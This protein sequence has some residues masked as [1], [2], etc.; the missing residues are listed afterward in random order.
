MTA[1]RVRIREAGDGVSPAGL[2]E[3]FG[4]MDGAA[5]LGGNECDTP[6][7]RFSYWMAE[8]V[9]VLEIPTSHPSPLEAIVA[10]TTKHTFRGGD[11]LPTE[12]MLC[13]GWVGY[14][15]YDL[16]RAI[17]RISE[18][19][20]DDMRM[21]L[22]RMGFYDRLICR[23]RKAGKWWLVVLEM[24]DEDVESKFAWL[25]ARLREAGDARVKM[26]PAAAEADLSKL[27]S[28]MTR[29]YY[30]EAMERIRKYIWDGEFYQINLS[31]RF[32]REFTGRAVDLF[33]WQSAH[34]ACPYA[35]YLD[36]GRF[37]VASASMEMF[38]TIRG[39]QIWTSPIKGTR[40]RMPG[41]ELRNQ[42]SVRE[43]QESVKERA[44]LNM[45]IDLER[46]DLG[47]ICEYGSIS[48][49]E[50][51]HV[52]AYPTVFHALATVDG[53]LREGV[54]FCEVLRA[55]FPG[56]SITGAPKIR[57]MEAIEELEPTR[58][59]LYTGSIGYIGVDG[60]VC[61]NI[62]IRTIII[63]GGMAWA[64]TGGGI[65][66]DSQP[67]AEWE[68]TLTK[69]MALAAGIE[70]VQSAGISLWLKKSF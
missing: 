53:T 62:A 42:Q 26:W 65:V 52:E 51:R 40:R 61:L 68:E 63:S 28:N 45:V 16:G 56:G 37:K 58:R 33:Q 2:N 47:R 10:A 34:N 35:A 39:R 55:M 57:V 14:F 54:G 32:C 24:G 7:N 60:N 43:L 67:Q 41:A 64:Q 66:A 15:S 31:Q 3:V 25:E 50:P 13:G 29:E 8:P 19:A 18:R 46:N 27:Q 9:E 70:A 21:P 11:T 69:V 30:F 48:V 36:A 59:G 38:L 4:T 23:D 17:E 5:I 1:C 20:V 49:V 12:G 44:E 6:A 22:V